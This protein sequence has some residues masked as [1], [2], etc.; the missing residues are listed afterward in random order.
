MADRIMYVKPACPYC[1]Q[2]RGRLE[3]LGL[4]WEERD[5]TAD[6]AWKSE[7]FMY[8]PKGIVPTIVEGGAVTVGHDGHG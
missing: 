5:A 7:L 1:E 2:A 8:S 3:S 4:D 6:P